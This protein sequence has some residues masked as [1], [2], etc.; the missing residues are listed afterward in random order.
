MEPFPHRYSVT[1]VA[2]VEGDIALEAARLPAL[3]SALPAEFGG[4]GNRWSPETLLVAAVA[5]CFAL[6]FR[7]VALANKFAWTS[8]TCEVDGTVDRVERLL[9]FTGYVL[10][11]KLCVPAGTDEEQAQ[12]LLARTEQTCLVGNSLK[13][14]SRLEATV[15]VESCE[16]ANEHVHA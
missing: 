15:E 16:H 9:Q 1:A 7:G 14:A 11:V 3:A 5:D 13:A 10:R 12:R 2:R 6:T 4:P 8:L